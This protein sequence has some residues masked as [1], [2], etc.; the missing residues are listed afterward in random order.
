MLKDGVKRP[1]E[2]NPHSMIKNI[3]PSFWQ[4]WPPPT[5]TVW[6][7]MLV[8]PLWTLLM[9][10]K[11]LKSILN[12]K[13]KDH[14]PYLIKLQGLTKKTFPNKKNEEIKGGPYYFKSSHQS[15]FI[16]A[17]LVHQLSSS[18]T[19]LPAILPYSISYLNSMRYSTTTAFHL[20]TKYTDQL[21]LIESSATNLIRNSK[22][23]PC[24]FIPLPK[25]L[26]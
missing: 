25:P 5:M 22:K 9:Q 3:W 15:S 18:L 2:S 7:A 4:H 10:E 21:P 24:N 17:T 8:P 19:L 16:Q 26:S 11:G 23:I 13:I 12:W 14:K 6:L 20:P 1:F